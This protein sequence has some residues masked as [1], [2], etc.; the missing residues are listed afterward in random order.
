MQNIAIAKTFTG[1]EW[2]ARW[3]DTAFYH[4]L[5]AHRNEKEA[6]EFI[7]ALLSD[8]QP[9]PHSRM[10]DLGCGTGRHSRYL[11]SKG[12]NVTGIDLAASSIQQAKKWQSPML[13]FC[14]QDMRLPF[15]IN[16]FDYVFNFFTSFGYFTD[17]EDDN[18]VI[19]NIFQ[20]LKPGGLFVMDYINSS[21]AEKTSIASEEKEID[22]VIYNITRWA[23][24]THFFKK[25]VIDEPLFGKPMEY[26]EQVKKFSLYDLDELFYNNGLKIVDCF[27]D[28]Q[29]NRYEQDKSPRI[30]LIAKKMS[31][32]RTYI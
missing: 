26:T 25:I 10:L 8:L 12:F 16:Q 22:G 20:S 32:E 17:P 11:A 21:Y 7:D 30:I 9:V 3:F 4:K 5:Y 6:A 18:Q 19:R 2:F 31:H 29:L 24:E 27:G 15:G 13:R 14:R 28:Y 23:N 1:R